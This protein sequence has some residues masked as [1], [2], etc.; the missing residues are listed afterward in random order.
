MNETSTSKPTPITPSPRKLDTA[1]TNKC[2][3]ETKDVKDEMPTRLEKALSAGVTPIMSSHSQLSFSA[4]SPSFP[5]KDY[6]HKVDYDTFFGPV[7]LYNN[8]SSSLGPCT[9]I[10]GQGDRRTYDRP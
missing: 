10:Y 9:K 1:S 8:T 7:V 5:L 3:Y 4:D 6:Q 2:K